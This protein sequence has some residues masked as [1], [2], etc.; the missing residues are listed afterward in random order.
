M[1]GTA[2]GNVLARVPSETDL[3]NPALDNIY[4]RRSVRNFTDDRVPNEVIGEILRAGTYAPSA[5]NQQPWRFVVIRN[6]ELIKRYGQQAKKLWV[7]QYKDTTDQ[8]L[9]SLTRV[10]SR[11]ET[12]IFYGAPVLVLVFSAPDALRGEIDCSLAAQNMML[13][14]RSLGIGSC[15]IGLASPLGSDQGFRKEIGVPENFALIAPLI[16]GYPAQENTRVPHRDNEVLL[17]WID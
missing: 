8:R 15:W 10:M 11:P 7:E 1:L 13:A 2:N 6:P 17:K 12:D 3:T 9:A 5:T 14:A 16:F 4:A